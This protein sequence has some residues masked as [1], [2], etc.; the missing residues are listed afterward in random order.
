MISKQ[1]EL[2]NKFK[3]LKVK[4]DEETMVPREWVILRDVAKA[5][6]TFSS[7]KHGIDSSTS[8]FDKEKKHGENTKLIWVLAIS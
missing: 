4:L 3:S 2:T 7:V 5:P 6:A 8:R 1:K